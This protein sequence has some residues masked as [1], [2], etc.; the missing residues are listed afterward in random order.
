MSVYS[1]ENSPEENLS[2]LAENPYPGRLLVVG[3]A[4]DTAVQAYAVEGRSE[5][6]RNRKLIEEDNIVGTEIAD[7]S[8]P[9]G[10]PE[11]T[12]YD[13]MRSIGDI[14]IVSNGNQTNRVVQYLRSGKA[15]KDA[16]KVTKRE[17][18]EP[19]FTPRITGF[20]DLNPGE[21][22]PSI[23][24]SVI[25]KSANGHGSIR[26]LYT[27]QSPELSQY[28]DMD[29]V[30]YAVHTYKGNVD[31]LPSYNEPPFII[32]IQNTSYGMASMLWESLDPE[33][34]VAVAAKTIAPNGVVNI[35]IINRH[36]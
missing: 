34:R 13:A 17:P 31:P 35:R 4:G 24:L 16:M 28:S 21:G 12:I 27:D 15:F 11:L 8:L 29:N 6:S 36:D 25:R 32:P 20:I 22:E 10:D 5:G 33:N 26:R 18:D 7:P 2:I 1:P 30:G 9:V 23:G 3:F 14:H 19:N